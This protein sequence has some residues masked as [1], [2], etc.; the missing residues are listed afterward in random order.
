MSQNQPYTEILNNTTLAFV[1]VAESD[2]KYQSE[3]REYSLNA[4]VSK[5]DAKAF[6]K[7][8]LKQS[9]KDYE[10]DEFKE[11][12]KI[13]P[14]FPDQDEQY[15]LK[16]SKV[17]VKDGVEVNPKYRPRVYL[18]DGKGNLTDITTSRLVANGSKGDVAYRV[19]ENSFG[20]FAY[21]EA[22][23][24]TEFIEYKKDGAANP[25]GG[26][27]VAVEEDNPEATQARASHESEKK[28]TPVPPQQPSNTG[29]DPSDMDDQD[30]PF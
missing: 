7:K 24:L 6:K 12:F 1:K 23:R 18:D 11:K 4:I 21:L 27:V 30:L 19:S 17:H 13:D 14:P 29:F 25:F 26:R 3:D 16:L 15:V 28:E 2:N 20:V 8:F 22:V 5:A 9:V 10:N